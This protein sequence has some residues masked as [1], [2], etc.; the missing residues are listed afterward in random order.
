VHVFLLGAEPA[1]ANG[2]KWRVYKEGIGAVITRDQSLPAEVHVG[3]N[4]DVHPAVYFSLDIYFNRYIFG[5]RIVQ[6]V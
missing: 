3:R 6:S 4:K 1:W 2:C 5:A